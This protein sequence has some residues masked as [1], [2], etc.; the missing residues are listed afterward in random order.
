[1]VY[2]IQPGDRRTDSGA[3]VIGSR[4][5][6]RNPK[7]YLYETNYFEKPFYNNF[8]EIKNNIC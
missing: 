5:T 6:V 2:E 8:L 3:L 4:F 7:N 1:M